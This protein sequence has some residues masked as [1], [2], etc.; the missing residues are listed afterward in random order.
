A[1]RIDLRAD[2]SLERAGTRWRGHGEAYA[3]MINTDLARLKQHLPVPDTLRN[4]VGSLRFWLKFSPERVDEIVADLAMR[5][6]RAQLAAD[7]LPLDLASISGRA[8]YRVN[9]D[10]FTFA[11]E[12]LRFRLASGSEPQHPGNFMF[13]RKE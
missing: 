11:T 4:G 1:G 5:N 13:T 6:A 9:P 10:G 7:V 12:N 3:E 8:I 2:A